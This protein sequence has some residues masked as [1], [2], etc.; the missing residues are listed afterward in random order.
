MENLEFTKSAALGSLESAK[1]H[2]CE[3]ADHGKTYIQQRPGRV[4]LASVLL[5]VAVA[6]LTGRNRWGRCE[7]PGFFQRLSTKVESSLQECPERYEGAR[8]SLC[9]LG[10]KSKHLGNQARKRLHELRYQ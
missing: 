9:E 6:M 2:L 3:V 4:I 7:S 5:G 8:K 10:R 1:H